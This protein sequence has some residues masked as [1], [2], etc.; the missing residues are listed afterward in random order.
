[1]VQQSNKS[2]LKD[3]LHDPYHDDEE[4]NSKLNL[5][6]NEVHRN[7]GRRTRKTRSLSSDEGGST[8]K[9]LAQSE[10]GHSNE[11]D[12]TTAGGGG[13]KSGNVALTQELAKTSLQATEA[14]PHQDQAQTPNG[15]KGLAP[16]RDENQ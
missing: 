13:N 11:D 9:S 8:S 12:G 16:A 15:E 10:P 2:D 14:T 5:E 1:M 3:V 4:D 7:M 6:M